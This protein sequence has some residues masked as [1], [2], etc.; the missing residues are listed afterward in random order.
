[1]KKK[2]AILG[3]TGSIGFTTLDII[4]KNKTAIFYACEEGNI[5]IIKKLLEYP[6]CDIYQIINHNNIFHMVH[7]L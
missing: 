4:C 5:N 7:F 3:S 1:M 6:E 2:I